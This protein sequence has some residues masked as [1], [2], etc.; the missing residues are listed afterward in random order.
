LGSGT[1]LLILGFEDLHSFTSLNGVGSTIYI[2]GPADFTGSVSAEQLEVDPL[3]NVNFHGLVKVTQVT[4]SGKVSIDVG[5]NTDSLYLS[6]GILTGLGAFQTNNFELG[7]S[8]AGNNS[9]IFSK[10]E[11]KSKGIVSISHV[12]LYLGTNGNFQIASGAT[13]VVS[14]DWTFL[15]RDSNGYGQITLL[16]TISVAGTLNSN[17]NYVG[18]G[19]IS[20]SGYLHFASNHANE[21]SIQ[22][23][24]TASV[25]FDNTI[26]SLNQ[27]T[28][29]GSVNVSSSA[30]TQSSLGKVNIA[31]L[32]VF[33]GPTTTTS[34]KLS[35]TLQIWRG[36]LAL[37]SDSSADNFLFNGGTLSSDGAVSFNA[38]SIVLQSNLLKTISSVLVTGKELSSS[39]ECALDLVNDAEFTIN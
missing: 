12:Y 20:V 13:L 3:G 1:K 24:K 22:T 18:T 5:L 29:E 14:S 16:G 17:V 37:Q 33:G 8:G 30:A 36:E 7:F 10:V 27:I 34:L 25:S 31:N 15:D 9:F 26:L 6:G 23:T 32:A 4:V 38:R 21:L 19:T 35:G 39:C 11:V 28:G 2:G